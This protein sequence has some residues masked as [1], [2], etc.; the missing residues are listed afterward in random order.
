MMTSTAPGITV[1]IANYNGGALVLD[2]LSSVFSQQG[3]FTLEVLVHDDAS[4]DGSMTRIR[5]TYPSVTLL[6]SQRNVGFCISNNR[7]VAAARGPFVL[8]L[9]NDA[10]LR[11]GSLEALLQGAEKYGRDCVLGLP[12][13]TLHGDTLVDRGYCS[14]P[15]L[16]PIPI[17]DAGD[18]EAGIVTGACLWTTKRVWEDVGGLPDFF[19]SLAED[20]HF[21]LA[22][23][24]LG[25]RVAVLDRPAF[26][27]WIGK[28]LGGGKLVENRMTTTAR[29]RTLSERNK[30][31][32]M[33]CC[34]PAPA[35]ALLMPLHAISL[36]CEA[37]F[38]ALSGTGR[39]K[40]VRIYGSIPGELWRNR[41]NISALRARLMRQRTGGPG[42][43][44]AFT[45][46]FPHKLT[47]LLGHGRPHV[48]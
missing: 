12:Q 20:I 6:E 23:R 36:A 29:R 11:P 15:F 43:V 41:G 21:C 47:M 32:S 17:M 22:A 37:L 40:V 26:D 33:L 5:E 39:D 27:H 35:L 24:L 34:Y 4:T 7:M 18:H 25:Y 44:F 14:D 38:L 45:R 9:N 13:Y 42:R 48:D 3:S 30:T 8:L 10:V 28:N 16:N 1:C 19:E 46:W 2:C 31:F